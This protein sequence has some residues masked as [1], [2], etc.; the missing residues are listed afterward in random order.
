MS[1]HLVFNLFQSRPPGLGGSPGN[2]DTSLRNE[3]AVLGT[4]TKNIRPAEQAVALHKGTFFLS[5]WSR[6]GLQLNWPHV[7]SCGLRCIW[8]RM[9]KLLY[10]VSFI[11][12]DWF[13]WE[14]LESR[15]SQNDKLQRTQSQ[16]KYQEAKSFCEKN[17]EG[18]GIFSGKFAD[19]RVYH[20]IKC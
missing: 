13:N 10:N 16:I 5:W 14:N 18:P 2:Q 8:F 20:E 1:R 19:E 6:I 11:S 17:W 15:I 9:T 12:T 7:D 4:G 3:G